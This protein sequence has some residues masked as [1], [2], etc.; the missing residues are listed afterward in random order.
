MHLHVSSIHVFQAPV[1]ASRVASVITS[2]LM[3]LVNSGRSRRWF[4]TV[5][6]NCRH[7]MTARKAAHRV[8][9]AVQSRSE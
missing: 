1:S 3:L 5:T 9:S 2:N 4:E 7:K 8:T 6:F